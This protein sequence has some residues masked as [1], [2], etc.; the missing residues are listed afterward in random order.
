[1]RPEIGSKSQHHVF[2]FVPHL[3]L[4]S[5][6]LLDL[7]AAVRAVILPGSHCFSLED[8]RLFGHLLTLVC[9]WREVRQGYHIIYK[10]RLRTLFRTR[11]L[12]EPVYRQCF[13]KIFSVL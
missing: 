1:M 4:D 11:L 5:C 2:C 3:L 7:L 10:I 6:D 8:I 12:S 9:Y 13:L